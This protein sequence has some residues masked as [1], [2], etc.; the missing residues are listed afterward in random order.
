MLV[1]YILVNREAMWG[2]TAG[3]NLLDHR[4][5]EGRKEDT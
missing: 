4:R 5:K 1:S 2:G 3:N